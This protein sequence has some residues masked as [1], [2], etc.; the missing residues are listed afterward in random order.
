MERTSMAAFSGAFKSDPLSLDH[1]IAG[2]RPVDAKA[3]SL[4]PDPRGCRVADDLRK[5]Q[6]IA[7]I[8]DPA[9]PG[10]PAKFLRSAS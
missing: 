2:L 9:L 10:Q 5:G 8:P 7:E 6:R 3:L 1:R 4:L